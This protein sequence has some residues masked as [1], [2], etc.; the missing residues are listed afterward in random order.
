MRAAR[1]SHFDF[2]FTFTLLSLSLSLHFTVLHFASL[3]FTFTLPRFLHFT[4]LHLTGTVTAVV[5]VPAS[6]GSTLST[7]QRESV[8]TA[9]I[10]YY[11]QAA[12]EALRPTDFASA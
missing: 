10:T 2:H 6:A 7:P 3:R 9:V 5:H 1:Y 8:V 12:T 11:G 4:S